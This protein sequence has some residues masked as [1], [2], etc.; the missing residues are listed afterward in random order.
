M[1]VSKAASTSEVNTPS[2]DSLTLARIL[3]R[4]EG[5]FGVRP[6]ALKLCCCHW[7]IHP[8][9][10]L[11][12]LDETTATAVALATSDLDLPVSD[13]GLIG[14]VFVVGD[15]PEEYH[16][17][18]VKAC[19]EGGVWKAE[20]TRTYNQTEMGDYTE[21]EFEALD[22]ELL[23]RLQEAGVTGYEAKF[24]GGGDSGQMEYSNLQTQDDQKVP[25]E[26][27]CELDDL[28]E[29]LSGRIGLDWYNNEGGG[30]NVT[31]APQENDGQ[32]YASFWYY[33]SEDV[34]ETRQLTIAAKELEQAIEYVRANEPHLLGDDEG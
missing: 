17:G 27:R 20:F 28:A 26:L 16:T 4:A 15:D 23:S 19:F 25:S 9:F 14:E 3:V 6:T 18:E 5:K 24:C 33:E 8:W 11:D 10:D 31:W 1:T 2:D 12:E 32:L 7:E 29:K 34:D 30:G 13:P 21:A 22:D